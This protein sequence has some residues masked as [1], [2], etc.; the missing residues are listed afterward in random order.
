MEWNKYISWSI[1]IR[2]VNFPP[3]FEG[4]PVLYV[5]S[6]FAAGGF[7][8]GDSLEGWISSWNEEVLSYLQEEGIVEIDFRRILREPC[9]FEAVIWR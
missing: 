5:H 6:Y 2:L 3:V 9:E 1:Q 8:K 4:A 7:V